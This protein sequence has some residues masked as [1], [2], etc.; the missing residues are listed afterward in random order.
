MLPHQESCLVYSVGSN[1]ET[2]FEESVRKLSS[3]C[4][5]HTFDPTINVSKL[6][7]VARTHNFT[8]HP[9]GLA[10]STSFPYK[11]LST[12]LSDLGHANRT[13]D[14]L[15]VDCEGCE[16]AAMSEI[17]KACT[18]GAVRIG[19]FLI[20]MH[21]TSFRSTNEFFEAADACGLMI[22]HKE[23]NHWGCG[24][25]RCVEYALVSNQSALTSFNYAHGCSLQ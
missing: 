16:H 22:F 2:S 25:Y 24:G 12:I 23:R 1:Y 6:E 15:K 3:T 19:Q 14:I 21:G 4:E 9:W 8:V 18:Q 20:E 11:T 17:S 13:I 7:V 5:I 10:A